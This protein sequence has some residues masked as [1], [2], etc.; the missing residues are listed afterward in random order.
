MSASYPKW[1]YDEQATKHKVDAYS[2]ILTGVSTKN[3]WKGA[4]FALWM[5]SI[6]PELN[7]CTPCTLNIYSQAS[8]ERVHTFDSVWIL[9]RLNKKEC[10]PRTLDEYSHASRRYSIIQTHSYAAALQYWTWQSVRQ[11]VSEVTCGNVPKAQSFDL[12]HHLMCLEIGFICWLISVYLFS[13]NKLNPHLHHHL[14][15][16]H[17]T[18]PTVCFGHFRFVLYT[19]FVLLFRFCQADGQTRRHC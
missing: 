18:A 2:C 6:T 3:N 8:T 5:S 11:S 16:L 10:T 9:P 19:L 4:H 13:S 7:N 14:T 15:W 12:S 17:V 1:Q